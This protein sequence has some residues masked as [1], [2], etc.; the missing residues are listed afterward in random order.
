[1]TCPMTNSWAGTCTVLYS[2]SVLCAPVPQKAK[3]VVRVFPIMVYLID[4]PHAA[5]FSLSCFL[6]GVLSEPVPT[7]KYR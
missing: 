4:F 6:G 3:T 7:S 5:E 2:P 1:M